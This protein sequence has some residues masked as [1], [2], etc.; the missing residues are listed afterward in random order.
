MK[1]SLFF[2][3]YNVVFSNKIW[4][5][6]SAHILEKGRVE[7]GLFQPKDMANQF[8]EFSVHPGW[9]FLIPNFEIK[10][11]RIDFTNSKQRVLTKLYTQLL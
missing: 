2:I 11:S 7:I 3:L 4:N 5:S 1:K 10:E 6:H 9:L 8:T